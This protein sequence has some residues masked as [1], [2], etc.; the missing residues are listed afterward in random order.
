[1]SHPPLV[2]FDNLRVTF[3]TRM[4]ET[5]AVENLS[6][7]IAAGE[8]VCLVGESGSGKSV[9][10][11]A[12]MQLVAHERGDIASGR[13]LWQAGR[14]DPVDLTSYPNT[15][16]RGRDVAMIF[17][18]PSTAL[19][20]V[21]SIGRQIVEGLCHHEG[22]SFR[23]A[24]A[25]ALSL[26]E[27]VHLPDP[28]RRMR[29]FPHELSGGMRQR[30]MIAMALA[31]RPHLLIADEPTTA[32]DV[33]TQAEILGLIRDLRAETGLAI[34]FITHDM[35]VVAQMADRVVVLREGR[36]IEE[37]SA[38]QIFDHPRQDYTKQLLAA[39]PRLGTSKA[40]PTQGDPVPLLQ[41]EHLVTR[42][43]VR[44]GFWRRAAQEVHAVQDVSFS[45]GKGRTLALVGESGC[46]KSTLGRS[47]LRL[48]EPLS[49]RIQL[50][51]Q[52]ILGLKADKLRAVRRDMQMI[53]Q[54]PLASLDPRMRLID[55]VKAPL[56]H[57]GL[58]H[59]VEAAELA[60]DLF[61]RVGLSRDLLRRYPHELSGGQRQRVCIAR[62]LV[63]S[64]RLIVADEAVSALDVSVQDRVLD[65][66]LDLQAERGLSYLFISHDLAVV[67]RV[68]HDVAVM[69]LGRIVE[70]GPTGSV[71]H[72]P[73]HKYTKSLLS[74]VPL[75]DP[76]HRLRRDLRYQPL[77]APIHKLGYTPEPPLYK[78]VTPGH[79]VL[80]SECGYVA[81]PAVPETLNAR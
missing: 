17:Q 28:A 52:D 53:F 4:G 34:L 1:M 43:P 51:G 60:A 33:T 13:V 45:L 10:A 22:L 29:Q 63:A 14:E 24:E 54:D 40:P 66:L 75:P 41:V 6:L 56:K 8:T 59:G 23:E 2:R 35:A 81:P 5:V 15:A 27:R 70:T 26:L 16:W 36:K 57:F 65:L 73:R 11:L 30:V 61:D 68:S 48:T 7:D 32:L 20:P 9:S 44:G 19:N 58:A 71:L 72:D 67:E 3:R 39:V 12:L 69:Y 49:G 79:L 42:Y 31:C 46:G 38:R 62:A 47:V 76:S 21:L 77:S 18:E 64:P 50:G 37:G 74:A 55:Q 80:Q 78:E 25:R